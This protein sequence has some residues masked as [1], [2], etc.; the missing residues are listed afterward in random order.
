MFLSS[1]AAGSVYHAVG[2]VPVGRF[3]KA[4]RQSAMRGG[5]SYLDI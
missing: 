3:P 4:V 5:E 2:V 1:P